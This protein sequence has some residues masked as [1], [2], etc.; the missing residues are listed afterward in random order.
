[1]S[2]SVL[3]ALP[4]N[5]MYKIFA[6]LDECFTGSV[7]AVESDNRPVVTYGKHLCGPATGLIFLTL[8]TGL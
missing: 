3:K 1:M 8:K 7:P 5:F 2:T 4:G 6:N